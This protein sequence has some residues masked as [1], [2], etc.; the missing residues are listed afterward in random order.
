VVR[1]TFGEVDVA[2]ANAG[3]EWTKMRA[4]RPLK[5]G[6]STEREPNRRLLGGS[7]GVASCVK[8]APDRSS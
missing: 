1:D 6:L 7:C 4:T 2:Y 5:N 8:D 3:I